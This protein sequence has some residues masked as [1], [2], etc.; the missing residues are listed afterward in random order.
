MPDT[1][2]INYPIYAI[3]LHILLFL[4]EC[5]ERIGFTP[6]EV[7]FLIGTRNRQIIEEIE[8]PSLK[9]RLSPDKTS[10]KKPFFLTYRQLSVYDPELFNLCRLIYDFKLE[11]CFKYDSLPDDLID[12][13]FEKKHIPTG[14]Q[15][16]ITRQD[17]QESFSYNIDTTNIPI[18]NDAE[19]QTLHSL[20]QLL[21]SPGF[22]TPTTAL[23]IFLDLRQEHGKPF[24]PTYIERALNILTGKSA[25]GGKLSRKRTAGVRLEFKNIILGSE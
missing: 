17:T 3:D 14:W 13:V 11:D 23:D 24:R 4:Q 9:L 6:D 7:G 21:N 2:I 15:I 22:S 12:V 25:R 19:T 16:S 8:D 10:G 5:R 20:E 18:D 1:I